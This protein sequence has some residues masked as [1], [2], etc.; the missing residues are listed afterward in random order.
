MTK[1]K[2]C[3][4]CGHHH[5]DERCPVCGS[6]SWEVKGYRMYCPEPSC[7]GIKDHMGPHTPWRKEGPDPGLGSTEDYTTEKNDG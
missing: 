2:L 3:T 1:E 4:A 5:H 7:S 6:R